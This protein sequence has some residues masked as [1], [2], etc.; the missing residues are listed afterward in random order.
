LVPSLITQLQ[1]Y[2]AGAA[3]DPFFDVAA[4]PAPE[5]TSDERR[6][7]LRYLFQANPAHLIARYPRY[8]E[9]LEQYRGAGATPERAEGH[10]ST[11]DFAD[12]QVLS[13]LAWFDEYWLEE[14]EVA[15]LVAKGREFNNADQQYIA[16]RQQELIGR[17]LA[18][19]GEAARRGAIEISASPFY[20]PIL[21]LICD[22]D[23][24]AISSP[25]L[26]LPR[27]RFC[28]P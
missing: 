4:K 15:A 2:A 22:S 5:L 8:A 18:K 20:H 24:G 19:Y 14:P 25:G 12:L 28:H 11:Q 17:A 3:H 13:Q 26:A 16:G 10:F 1:D 21:P 9:L 7:A 23:V 6:F 27:E